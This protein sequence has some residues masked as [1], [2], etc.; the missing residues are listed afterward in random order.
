MVKP[1][2]QLL[3]D[4]NNDGD[5]RDTGEDVTARVARFEWQR[6]RDNASA[7]TGRSISGKLTAMLDNRS[8][9][10]SSFNTSS[11]L[12]GNVLPGRKVQL[13]S[14]PPLGYYIKLD[15]VDDEVKVTDDAAIQEIFASG[16]SVEALIFAKSDGE[17][18]AGRI[19][20][21]GSWYFAVALESGGKVA[22]EFGHTFSGTNGLWRTTALIDINTFKHAAVTYNRD[23]TANNP[24]FKING[25]AVGHSEIT[26]PT[27]TATADAG[28][29]LRIGNNVSGIRT[30]DGS[31]DDVRLWSDTR[32]TT[33][34]DDNKFLELVGTEAGLV[35]YWRFHEG[36][37]ST[38]ADTTANGNDGTITGA[39]WGF[40]GGILWTGFLDRV[41][42]TPSLRGPKRAQLVAF[43]PLA[44]INQRRLDLAMKTNILT[45]QAINDILD[46]VGWPTADRDIDTGQ[47][48][49]ARFWIDGINTL[50]SLRIVERSE[51]GFL[52]ETADGKIR[53]EDRHRRMKAPHITSQAT[54]SDGAAAT[55]RYSDPV[56]QDPLPFIFNGFETEIRRFTVGSL[57]TLWTLPESGANSPLIAQGESRTFFAE[58]PTPAAAL[59]AIAVDAW[60]TP[61]A[62]TDFTANSA[63]DGSG[64][65]LTSDIAIAVTKFA[66]SMK[67][68]VTNNGSVAAFLTLLKARGTPV[69]IDD[70]V[71]VTAEDATSQTKYGERTF[72]LVDH[73]IADTDEGQQWTDFNLA[74]YKSEIPVLR[75]GVPANVDN[76]HLIEVLERDVSDR[77]RITAT[78]VGTGLGIDEAFF[79]ENMKHVVTEEMRVHRVTYELSPASGY[80][81]FW[82]LGTSKL[83]SESVLA[84]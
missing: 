44:H 36:T 46:E 38:A 19:V 15:G 76:A 22:L 28:S 49:M 30:F 79:I 31:I 69:T 73:F 77:I 14:I 7:L 60:T 59:D 67:I 18:N 13:R 43:G 83:T 55:L 47:S 35:G 21:K 8:E 2:Y 70:P 72:P 65:D 48:T 11:P 37:G 32:T 61:V 78:S 50:E 40:I 17:G 82:T 51:S 80:S 84:Y 1:L 20:D 58:Y 27:G 5:F 34:V 16:G 63:S 71:K 23:S 3:I 9:D 64:T 39:T 45:G 26:T 29:D 68:A 10:Y 52:R 33:E 4:W 56:Q 42:P 66:T 57:A 53:F 25:A 12:A 62:T 41:V 6:G 81:G 54:F 74:I 24:S 75:I